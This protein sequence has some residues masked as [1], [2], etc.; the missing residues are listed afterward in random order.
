MF[1]PLRSLP[2]VGPGKDPP[3]LDDMGVG[4]AEPAAARIGFAVS[5]PSDAEAP[6]AICVALIKLPPPVAWNLAQQLSEHVAAHEEQYDAFTPRPPA[7][8]ELS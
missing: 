6:E 4:L 2:G 8:E 1:L 3:V 7:E 5:L